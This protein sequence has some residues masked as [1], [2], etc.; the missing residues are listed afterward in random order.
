MED[1]LYIFYLLYNF[2]SQGR[3]TVEVR[4]LERRLSQISV[5]SNNTFGPLA[6]QTLIITARYLEHS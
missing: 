4:Y 1:D 3:F 2:V 5:I 6:G